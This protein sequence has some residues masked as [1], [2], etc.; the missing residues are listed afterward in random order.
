M[1][2]STTSPTTHAAPAT[3]DT[4]SEEFARGA[5]AAAESMKG[6]FQDENQYPIYNVSNQELESFEESAVFAALHDEKAR[7]ERGS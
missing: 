7:I 3:P 1:A 6:Y 2:D 5:R 4:P